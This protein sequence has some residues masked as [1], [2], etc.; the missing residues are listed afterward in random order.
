MIKLV[1]LNKPGKQKD[2]VVI[3]NTI[4]IKSEKG[5]FKLLMASQI[6]ITKI[7]PENH[8]YILGLVNKY[9]NKNIVIDLHPTLTPIKKKWWQF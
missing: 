1:N 2:V 3:Y 5:D 6:D 9:L 7:D 8:N 4:D